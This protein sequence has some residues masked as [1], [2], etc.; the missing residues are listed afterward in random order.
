MSFVHHA[1][2]EMRDANEVLMALY[3]HLLPAAVNA[4]QPRLLEII[5]GLHVQV[6]HFMHAALAY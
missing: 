5:F 2:G 4:K 6:I 1:T 3:D